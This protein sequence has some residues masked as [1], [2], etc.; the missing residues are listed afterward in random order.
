MALFQRHH[1]GAVASL[2][3]IITAGRHQNH[4]PGPQ[5]PAALGRLFGGKEE[6]LGDFPHTGFIGLPTGYQTHVGQ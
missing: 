6:A 3:S 4:R 2:L 5:Y 1:R